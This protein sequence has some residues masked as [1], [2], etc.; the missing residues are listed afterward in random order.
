MNSLNN[1]EVYM[2]KS[3]IKKPLVQ[4]GVLLKQDKH[5]HLKLLCIHKGTEMSILVRELILEYLK[6]QQSKEELIDTLSENAHE[7]WKEVRIENTGK[8]GWKTAKQATVNFKNFLTR[9]RINLRRKYLQEN[10]IDI[11]TRK[12]EELEM[13]A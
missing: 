5:D 7:E 1:K 9:I 3:K 8:K 4:C 12:I 10:Y 2:F 11:I 6:T 13:D